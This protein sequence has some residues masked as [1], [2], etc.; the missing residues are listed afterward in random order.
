MIT[1]I[2]ISFQ[3]NGNYTILWN[4]YEILKEI[5]IWSH[6]IQMAFKLVFNLLFYHRIK[7]AS[8]TLFWG[9]IIVY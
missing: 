3:D 6:P 1:D 2:L 4:K 5:F 8:N 7:F 9:G